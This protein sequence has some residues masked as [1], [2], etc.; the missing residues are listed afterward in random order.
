MAGDLADLPFSMKFQPVSPRRGFGG[1]RCPVPLP[2]PAPAA[3]H[4]PIRVVAMWLARPWVAR[5]LESAGVRK[6]LLLIVISTFRV[7]RD[8]FLIFCPLGAAVGFGL[9]VITPASPTEI[10]VPTWRSIAKYPSSRLSLLEQP[11][12][13]VVPC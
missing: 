1:P 8:V 5:P 3:V 10:V 2:C 9:Q 13:R 6:L 7:G 4:R 12:L 11:A